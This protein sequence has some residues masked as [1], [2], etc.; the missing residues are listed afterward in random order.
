MKKKILIFIISII[1]LLFISVFIFGSGRPGRG[2]THDSCHTSTGYIIG[3]DIIGDI[4][5][6][7]SSNVIFNITATGANIFVQ[8]IPD[9]E[10]NSLFII[11][12]TSGRIDETSIYDLDPNPNS[13]I[14]VFNITTPEEEGFYTIFII[15]GNDAHE[16]INFAYQIIYINV[17]GV[18]KPGFDLSSIFDHLGLYLGLPAL[19]LVTLGTILVLINE[20]KFVKVH[21]ILAGSSLVITVINLVTAIVKIPINNWIGV[22]PIIY[23]IPHIIFGT[24]GL[25]SGFFSMLFGIAAERKPAKITG[26]ITLICWWTAFF[27]GYF[28]NSNLLLL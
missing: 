23:H 11:Q 28:L 4:E 20:N 22:Y 27:L 17:G 25:I 18:A 5:T 14:V 2:D 9:A 24:I 7:T 16:Q 1:G 6:T 12:P 26:Y 13:I 19:L 15:A 10:D 21:G 3:A 8:I